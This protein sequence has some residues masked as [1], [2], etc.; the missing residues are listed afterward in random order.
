MSSIYCG[1]FSNFPS[2]RYLGTL[3]TEYRFCQFYSKYRIYSH[4]NMDIKT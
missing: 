4:G 2:A 1:F 3:D